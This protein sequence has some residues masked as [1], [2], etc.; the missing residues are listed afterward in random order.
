MSTSVKAAT[1]AGLAPVIPAFSEGESTGK[2]Y[3]KESQTRTKFRLEH[4]YGLGGV[5]LGNAFRPTTDRQAQ[6]A[7]EAAWEA[8]VRYFDTS[9]WYGL[10]LSE[11]RF[12]YFL[13]NQNREDYILSTKVGR[14]LKASK[15]PPE[16]MW[17]K[18]SP[19]DYEYDYSAQGVR[20]SVEDSLQRLGI[21]SIDIVFIHDLSPDNEDMKDNWTEYFKIAEKGAMPEL[22]KMR[23]EGLIKGWGLGVNTVEADPD[24]FLSATIYS[25]IEHEDALNRLFPVCERYGV[26][27]VAGAPLNSGFLAG[28]DRYNYSKDVPVAFK[29]KRDRISRIALAHGVDV[30]TAALQ[31]SAAPSV[32]SAVI[33]GTRYP[34]QAKANVVSMATKIPT[35]FWEELKQEGLIAAHAP[36]P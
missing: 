11:R 5:A 1:V 10:G 15:E 13:H 3:E 34:D 28:I 30:R 24:I 22:T 16:T 31:F 4:R 33:P 9:P 21:D 14:L 26:S 19:F 20:R 12:G 25:L 32:V 17:Q 7:M 18:P 29:E 8:G 6:E 23:E 35:A 2:P 36:T 27:V